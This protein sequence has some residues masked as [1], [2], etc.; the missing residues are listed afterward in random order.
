MWKFFFVCVE[1][2]KNLIL[3]DLKEK[4]KKIFINCDI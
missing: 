2:M 3:W 4:I 1:E